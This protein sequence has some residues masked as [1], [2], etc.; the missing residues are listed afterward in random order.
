MGIFFLQ[1][2]GDFLKKIIAWTPRKTLSCTKWSGYQIDALFGRAPALVPGVVLQP[3]DHRRVDR[4]DCD[5]RPEI[6][7]GPMLYLGGG[8]AVDKTM[9]ETFISSCRSVFHSNELC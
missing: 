2:F 5:L 9:K 4:P 3:H 8:N 6:V 7:Q 1:F